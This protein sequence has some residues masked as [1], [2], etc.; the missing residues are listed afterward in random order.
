MNWP[1]VVIVL[2]TVGAL[3]A[4]VGLLS[5]SITDLALDPVEEKISKMEDDISEMKVF[6]A[7]VDER[8]KVID[9]KLKKLEVAEQ[10]SNVGST[11]SV[12]LDRVVAQVGLLHW[13][14][15]YKDLYKSQRLLVGEPGSEPE[16]LSR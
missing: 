5:V 14:Q 3:L 6:L 12:N 15:W 7:R 9:D 10:G 4:T 1:T 8:Q 11:L 16:T 13:L 2:A